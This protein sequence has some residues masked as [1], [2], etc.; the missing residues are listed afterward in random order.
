[1]NIDLEDMDTPK[2]QKKAKVDT[3][4]IYILRCTDPGRSGLVKIGWTRGS[5]NK[6][7]GSGIESK[8]KIKLEN[9]WGS[10]RME[11]GRL[12]HCLHVEKLIHK[13]LANRRRK[14]ECNVCKRKK[15]NCPAIHNEWFQ[16]SEDMAIQTAK[17]WVKFMLH[18]PYNEYG[19]LKPEWEAHLQRTETWQTANEDLRWSRWSE[20]TDSP[21]ELPLS[22]PPPPPPSTLQQCRIRLAAVKE[23]KLWIFLWYFPLEFIALCSSA[24]FMQTQPKS[25]GSES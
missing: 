12:A 23:N 1:M 11:G 22:P 18:A 14:F 10:G 17:R 2:E 20:F 21:P 4:V 25:H 7:K 19:V 8:C 13:D 5:I 16:V 6:R 24:A 9:V 3:G 15:T